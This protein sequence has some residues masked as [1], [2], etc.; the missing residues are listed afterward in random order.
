MWAAQ[1]AKSRPWTKKTPFK[2]C[3]AFA[4]TLGIP[5]TLRPLTSYVPTSNELTPEILD[6]L[7]VGTRTGKLA[8]TA[9]DGRP[10]VAPIWFTIDDGDVVFNTGSTTAKGKSLQRDGRV[11]LAVD[12][13]EPPYAFVQIQGT[14]EISR[15]VTDA[16]RIATLL[17]ARYMGAERAEEYGA[18]NGVPGELTV[19]I[20]ASKV[21]SVF[22][23]TA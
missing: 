2:V 20:K 10:L 14:V 15:V 18:R 22:D 1:D 16:R 7:T 11:A 21:I 17:G 3:R 6:F 13:V 19:R 12:L 23:M 4:R 8:Y 9:G 5:A